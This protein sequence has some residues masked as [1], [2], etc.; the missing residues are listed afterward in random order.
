VSAL[1]L[2]TAPERPWTEIPAVRLL[3]IV[4]GVWLLIAA[5]RY[6]FGRRR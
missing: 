4:L 3:G 6:M 5:I 2:L 1:D